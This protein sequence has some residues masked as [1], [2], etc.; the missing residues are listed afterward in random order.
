MPLSF[1][2]ERSQIAQLQNSSQTSRG[3]GKYPEEGFGAGG[4]GQHPVDE[5]AVPGVEKTLGRPC[6]AMSCLGSH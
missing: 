5:W 6:G 3:K 4:E 2:P 1:I